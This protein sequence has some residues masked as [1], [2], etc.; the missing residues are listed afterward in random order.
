VPDQYF[1]ELIGVCGLDL[2]RLNRYGIP[3]DQKSPRLIKIARWHDS[4]R[5]DVV[6]LSPGASGRKPKQQVQ[7]ELPFRT[8]GG[9]REGAG[10]KPAGQRA[11]LPHVARPE[12]RA[13]H[14]VHVT[15]RAGQRLQCLRRQTA[16][17]DVRRAIARTSRAWFRVVHFSV[18]RDHVHLIV[19]AKDKRRLSR[20][21]AGLAI[22]A[23]RAVNGAL[24]RRGRVWADR[25]H[26]RPLRTPREVRHGLVYV[27]MNFKKHLRGARGFDSC[28]SAWWFEGWRT[29]PVSEPPAWDESEP[30]VRAPSRWLTTTGWKRYGLLGADER[31]RASF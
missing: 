27:L 30:P 20:G 15:L 11:G 18:Q 14:P 9:R 16:F 28:S 4:N 22:R 1:S 19:E 26:A 8:W 7:H 24:G 21:V 23:A 12:H 25:Y 5:V 2:H 13:T 29:P 31:R 17:L 6:R 3:R 10:R